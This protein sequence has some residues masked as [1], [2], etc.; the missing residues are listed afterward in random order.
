MRIAPSLLSADFTRLAEEIRVVAAA[1]ADRLHL[2][3]MDGHYVPNLT[4]GPLLVAAV[5]RATDLPL[6][7]HLMISNAAERIADYAEAGAN[8]IAVHPESVPQ[9]HQTLGGLRALDV[10]PG[11][12]IA[13]RTPL[14]ALETALAAADQAIV[15][16]VQPGRAG[17]QFLEGSMERVR[18]VRRIAERVN[19]DL[20]IVVDGGMNADRIAAARE[21]GADVVVAGSAIFAAADPAA[22]VR[23]MLAA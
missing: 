9:L 6:D 4:F 17:Q 21:A 15:M 2:D 13:P 10:R 19:P 18:Q 12:A 16:S 3:V 20:E 23:K 1:G 8:A 14:A 5:R 11:I 22:A 7:A